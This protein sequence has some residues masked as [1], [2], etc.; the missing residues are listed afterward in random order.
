MVNYRTRYPNKK[1]RTTVLWIDLIYAIWRAKWLFL[2]LYLGGILTLQE[3]DKDYKYNLKN[4]PSPV[5]R[6]Q[7]DIHKKMHWNTEFRRWL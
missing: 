2:G 1:L 3:W 4:N 5:W 7:Y 6:V